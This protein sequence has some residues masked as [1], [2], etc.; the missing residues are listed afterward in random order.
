MPEANQPLVEKF[1]LAF[2][3]LLIVFSIA[4]TFWKIIIKKDYIIEAQTDC[5]PYFQRCFIWKCDPASDVEGEKCVGDP[6]KDIWYYNIIR[7]NAG[8]IPLCDP[9]DENCAALIC[10]EGEPECEQIF[11]TEENKAEQ[12]AECNDPE[13]YIL[14]NPVKEE[15]IE[16]EESVDESESD[17]EE[18]APDDQNCL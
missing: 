10:D 8:R 6:E 7:R 15:T 3:F 11:C 2:L 1:F 18:C 14:D 17:I 4:V 9:N 5:D 16:S 13:Q 12:E